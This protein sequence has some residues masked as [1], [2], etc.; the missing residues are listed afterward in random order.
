MIMNC[1]IKLLL[2]FADCTTVYIA[3]FRLGQ[4]CMADVSTM[5]LGSGKYHPRVMI[6]PR[7][8]VHL[9]LNS[10][11]KCFKHGHEVTKSPFKFQIIDKR[12]SGG[13]P[14]H[15]TCGMVKCFGLVS[16]SMKKIILTKDIIKEVDI[17]CR[18]GGWGGRWKIWRLGSM[19]VWKMHYL[20]CSNTSVL[21][22]F[23]LTNLAYVQRPQKLQRK[24]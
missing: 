6:W 18:A 23:R 22:A 16:Y 20:N 2:W 1:G 14:K 13:K 12:R 21:T 10:M 3:T 24:W 9:L 19:M 4:L 8:A 5:L 17:K 15:N 11:A 7:F